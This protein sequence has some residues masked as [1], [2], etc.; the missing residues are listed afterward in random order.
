VAAEKAAASAFVSDR[1][2]GIAASGAGLF[3]AFLPGCKAEQQTL[4]KFHVRSARRGDD[5]C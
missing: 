1:A 2:A 4:L 3:R 5:F